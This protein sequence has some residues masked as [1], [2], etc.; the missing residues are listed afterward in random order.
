MTFG[1]SDSHSPP[2]S[3]GR[4]TRD[5]RVASGRPRVTG[6]AVV[7]FVRVPPERPVLSEME[8]LYHALSYHTKSSL[9][10][11]VHVVS[12]RCIRGIKSHLALGI[13]GA[14]YAVVVR[15]ERMAGVE[16]E[17][18]CAAILEGGREHAREPASSE[19]AATSRAA[20]H[21]CGRAVRQWSW[22]S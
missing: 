1:L 22:T 6:V 9:H 5:S 11:M 2:Y 10:L 19:R 3:G 15:V 17:R 4:A 21:T 20:E 7:R 14:C 16:R 12:G 8:L 18:D 13:S